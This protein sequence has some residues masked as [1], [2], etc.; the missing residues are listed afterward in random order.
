MGRGRETV[1]K[2]EQVRKNVIKVK[3]DAGFCK[4]RRWTINPHTYVHLSTHFMDE[5]RYKICQCKKKL[6]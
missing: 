3:E 6:N 5:N 4:H 2:T 1:P